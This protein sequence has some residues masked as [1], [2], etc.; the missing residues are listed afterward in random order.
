M[1]RTAQIASGVLGG[2]TTM[3][4]RAVTRRAAHKQSGAPR[5]PRAARRRNGFGVMLMWAAAVGVVLAMSDVLKEQRQAS[6][7]DRI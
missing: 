6:A 3:I 1:S 4:V 2:A 5:L 7:P